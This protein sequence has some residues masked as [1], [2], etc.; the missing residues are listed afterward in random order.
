MMVYYKEE[1]ENIKKGIIKLHK[2]IEALEK[3][4][5]YLEIRSMEKGER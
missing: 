4:K 2:R 5:S 3:E 1:I